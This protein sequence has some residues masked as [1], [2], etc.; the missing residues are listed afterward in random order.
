MKRA[1]PIGMLLVWAVAVAGAV[2]TAQVLRETIKLQESVLAT[3]SHDL[4]RQQGRIEQAWARVER[5]G[6]DLARAE[7]QGEDLDSL[8]LRDE[9]LQVAEGELLTAVLHSQRLRGAMIATRTQIEQAKQDLEKI[10]TGEQQGRDPL[11]GTWRIVV[12]PG[13]QDG[14]LSLSLDGTLVTGIY[15]LA[16]GW[17]GSFRGTLVAAKVRLERIDSQIGFAAIFYGR[18]VTAGDSSRLEG[19]WEAT[20]L[21]TGLPSSGTWVAERLEET[22][23]E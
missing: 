14:T 1:L 3:Q 21:A 8:R 10:G 16:G 22:A 23:S 9:D 4:E 15:S 2:P 13:G 7:A 12:E 18:L 17:N 19:T 6:A 5:L 20:Q 11:S